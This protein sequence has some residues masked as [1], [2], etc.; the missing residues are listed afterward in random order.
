MYTITGDVASTFNGTLTN[1]ASVSPPAGITDPNETDPNTNNRDDA[2]ITL[3]VNTADLGI[4]KT[5]NKT[6]SN[7]QTTVVYEL[8]VTNGGAANVTGLR[9]IDDVPDAIA[10]VTWTCVATNGT[11][12]AANGTG[13]LDTTVDLLN[14][15]SAVYRIT[16]TVP[17]NFSGALNNNARIEPP[18]TI[19]D[20]TPNNNTAVAPTTVASADV[21][22]T[23]DVSNNGQPGQYTYL[24][25]IRNN[26]P[27]TA[28]NVVVQD[29]LAT[30]ATFQ[31]A[32]DG[33]AFDSTTNRVNWTIGNL[34]N[35][36][37]VTR[38]VTVSLPD[39]NNTYTNIASGSSDI[40]DPNLGNNDGSRS[41][42]QVTTTPAAPPAELTI[43]TDGPTTF[44]P[45][46]TITYT[47]NLSNLDNVDALNAVLDNPSLRDAGFTFIP[48]PN[49]CTTLP[50]NLGTIPANS[51]ETITLTFKV[52]DNYELTTPLTNTA[53]VDYSNDPTPDTN[54]TATSPTRLANAD[55]ITTKTGERS[56]P[57]GDYTYTIRT[58][59]L[60]PDTA[61]NVQIYDTIP[62]GVTVKEI[63]DGGRQEGDRIL[64][65]LASLAP[66]AQNA[67]VR[68]V[69]LTLS[70]DGTYTN[71]ARSTSDTLDT[72]PNNN[73]GSSDTAKV[74]TIVPLEPTDV[75]LEI[76]PP[77]SFKPGEEITFTYTLTNNSPSINAE[78]V[79][80][81]IPL[82]DSLEF[83]STSCTNDLPCDFG[84][85]PAGEVRTITV[86]YRV[87]E[88]FSATTI[89]ATGNV[90][91]SNPDSVPTNNVAEQTTELFVGEPNLRLVKRITE[92]LRNGVR[93]AGVDFD[94]VV[95]DPSDADDNAAGWG[96]LLGVVTIP[97][98]IQLQSGDVVEYALYLLSD[99]TAAVENVQLCDLIPENTTFLTDTY[100][101][102]RG[103][104]LEL[105]DQETRLSNGADGDLGR[106]FPALNPV[107]APCSN[108]NN[109]NGA[110]WLEGLTLEPE[111]M[112]TLRFR[113]VV[114]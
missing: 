58:E 8:T 30:G 46:E 17:A 11:C 9:V 90:T 28:E 108:G 62:A 29:R 100:G 35:G 44:N 16:G 110:V 3:P 79:A 59:N 40:P 89:T 84:T 64:W 81:D 37:T 99:G 105:G 66:G 72:D 4:T 56:G 1:S 19:V 12:S 13:D 27:D 93:L 54:P 94:Q 50:C 98:S 74:E 14:G 109:P 76:Q 48:D 49:G 88:D 7:N 80:L 60:G 20:S 34:T 22:V 36:Q 45:G 63:S 10:N 87:P 32:S 70:D 95:D 18:N 33:G 43:A 71:I 38:S 91:L 31:T 113:V 68:T 24:L 47:V 15:G 112:A 96:D 86:T 2:P 103:M 52:P 61:T 106:Y 82:P 51:T 41:D 97:D 69:T 65:D 67:I 102:G 77:A 6:V 53:V 5:V 78:G 73:N 25:T 92:V 85:V 83:V 21:V 114:D 39:D 111:A 104:V 75:Q 42:A 23:K 26:G 55:L 107:T 101:T 57:L